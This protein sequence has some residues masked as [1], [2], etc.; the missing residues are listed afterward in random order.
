LRGRDVDAHDPHAVLVSAAAARAFWP[1]ADPLGQHLQFKFT[2]GVTWD[3]VGIVGDVKLQGLDTTGSDAVAYQW[4]AQRPWTFGIFVARTIGPPAG[5]AASL[6]RV[7]H[8][9]DPN[10]A[11]RDVSTMEDAIGATMAARRFEEQVLGVFAIVAL[12]LAAAGLYSVLA[13]ATRGQARE[14]AVRTALGASAADI[15][16]MV[17]AEGA[18]PAIG[19]IAVGLGGAVLLGP[20][21]KT[22]VFGVGALDPLTFASVAG[23]L[24]VVAGLAGIA[25]AYRAVRLDPVRVLRDE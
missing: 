7:I 5:L 20:V 22:L 16:R 3:V 15:I 1:N 2:P 25:P 17:A 24:L 4:R 13:H 10:Q 8:D 14:I 12:L 18:I 19:G 9:V 11:V 21:L 23:I 6:R